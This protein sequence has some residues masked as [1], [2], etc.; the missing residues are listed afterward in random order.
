M[1]WRNLVL[2]QSNSSNLKYFKPV[3]TFT[4]FATAFRKEIVGLHIMDLLL[5]CVTINQFCFLLH[6][7]CGGNTSQLRTLVME[8]L[9][10][11]EEVFFFNHC[12]CPVHHKITRQSY[13]YYIRIS[14]IEF[15]W[16]LLLTEENCCLSII[17]QT[18]DVLNLLLKKKGAP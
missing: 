5:H 12:Y 10:C 15:K 18:V 13:S 7:S 17:H 2:R 6:L 14:Q 16:N 8:D 4:S 3:W 11:Y 9:K 1:T